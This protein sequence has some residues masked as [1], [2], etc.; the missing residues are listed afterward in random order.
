MF[1]PGLNQTILVR[2]LSCSPTIQ[3]WESLL[4]FVRSR[5]RGRLAS[6][7]D[8]RTT[9]QPSYHQSHSVPLEV[10]P[11][12]HMSKLHPQAHIQAIR[13]LFISFTP[14]QQPII[15][16]SHPTLAPFLA[17]QATASSSSFYSGRRPSAFSLN[18]LP[19]SH[20]TAELGLRY[21]NG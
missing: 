9:P 4:F 11:Q 21:R 5:S 18:P 10:T 20:L 19:E 15:P 8:E 16:N 1:F 6:R 13:F 14:H 2:K 7:W 17:R 12:P 3:S